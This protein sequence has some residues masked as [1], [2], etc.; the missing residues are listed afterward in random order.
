MDDAETFRARLEA[1]GE[2][3]SRIYRVKAA[4]FPTA[5]RK[6]QRLLPRGVRRAALAIVAAEAQIGHPKLEKLLDF[7]HLSRE[8]DVVE[9][10]LNGIDATELRWTRM[11]HFLAGLAFNLL[12]VGL[13]VLAWWLWPGRS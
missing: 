7:T 13:L 6:T 10:H 8:A 5:L 11:I 2:E 12:V 3:L 1:L 4:D 9:T